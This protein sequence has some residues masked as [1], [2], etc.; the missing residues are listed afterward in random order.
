VGSDGDRE[1]VYERVLQA[2]DPVLQG[3]GLFQTMLIFGG[4]GAGKTHLF[5]RYLKSLLDHPDNPGALILDP[6]GVLFEWL[7]EN[8]SAERRE[9]LVPVTRDGKHR[10]D[11]L[12]APL[13]DKDIGRLVA[14]V[15][16]AESPSIDEGWA[17]LLVDL[18]ESAA[19][20][21]RADGQP[22]TMQSL[23]ASVL[24]RKPFR[25]TD[26]S[27]ILK[28]PIEVSAQYCPETTPDVSSAMDRIQQFYDV[29]STEERQRR[30]VRQLLSASLGEL[31]SSH[32]SSLS[33]SDAEF[34]LYDGIIS[35]HKV[36]LVS[37]GQQAP[38]F[39]RSLCSLIKAVFQQAVLARL[40]ANGPAKP[41]RKFFIL[42]T[43]EYAQVVT[44][45]RS[46]LVSDSQFFS[47]SREA[48]CMSLLALQSIATARSRFP[49]NLHDRWGGI[50]G[51]VGV[52]LFMRLNDPETAELASRLAGD[53]LALLRVDS[54]VT[55]HT[56]EGST[57]SHIATMVDRVPDW[58]LTSG[59]GQG[60]GLLHGTLNGVGSPV[61]VILDAYD[62]T[63]GPAAGRT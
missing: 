52:K 26:S 57:R 40:S 28:Y 17:V 46:G 61:S 47:Q 9:D 62:D 42:A 3:A 63:A 21:L 14:E 16:L 45:G 7:S 24:S 56:G 44:E 1:L 33:A 36:V 23:L 60:E 10:I 53:R 51:N 6:K 49:A 12:R 55:G 8:L 50:L 22:V 5:K 54:E 31:A 41:S 19:V 4:P 2:N 34:D 30:F 20:V 32:W 29:V 25:F 27:E 48:G 38:A 43:D 37:V 15:A 58:Y 13:D 59:L 11:L 35:E 39:Q 18:L